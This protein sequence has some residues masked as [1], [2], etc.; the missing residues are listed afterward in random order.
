MKKHAAATFTRYNTFESGGIAHS[1]NPTMT[2]MLDSC[3]LVNS[4]CRRQ[5]VIK[6]FTTEIASLEVKEEARESVR[7]IDLLQLKERKLL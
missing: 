1:T 7:E 4:T 6:A 5:E 3:Q 2:T